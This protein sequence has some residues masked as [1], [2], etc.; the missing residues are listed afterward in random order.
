M[1]ELYAYNKITDAINTSINIYDL[2][3]K[4]YYMLKEQEADII[5]LDLEV[6][7]NRLLSKLNSY[8]E[9]NISTLLERDT[10]K[11]MLSQNNKKSLCS[12]LEYNTI[13]SIAPKM[14]GYLLFIFVLFCKIDD[15]CGEQSFLYSKTT[16]FE[17]SGE[18]VEALEP[19]NTNNTQSK[20]LVYFTEKSIVEKFYAYDPKVYFRKSKEIGSL[21][22]S[23]QTNLFLFQIKESDYITM[24]N[25][26]NYTYTKKIL[27]NSEKVNIALIPFTNNQSYI[28]FI[29]N[30]NSFFVESLEHEK[31]YLAKTIDIL[32][33]LNLKNV[34]I[35]VFPEFVFSSSM[36]QTIRTFLKK[37]KN[38]FALIIFG[39]IWENKTNKCII[40]SGNGKILGEQNKLNRF[41]EDIR[42]HSLG[43]NE[44]IKLDSNNRKINIYDIEGLGRVNTPICIDFVTE[45]Y[46][47]FIE[48]IKV[49]ICFSP[50]YTESL[51]NFNINANRL[52]THNYAS[53]FLCNS[54]IPMNYK[55][56]TSNMVNKKRY[57]LL[58]SYIPLKNK[59]TKYMNYCKCIEPDCGSNLKSICVFW[60][61]F[62]L[63]RCIIKKVSL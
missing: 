13:K 36:L 17:N 40:L 58:F 47:K 52:G 26:I 39:T 2:Y 20:A 12:L 41:H 7:H 46:Y 31:V 23:Y 4:L 27:T 35:V 10:F 18:A 3:L 53:V 19:L 54:C 30:G 57:P 60:I 59:G 34:N 15:I 29:R 9:E 14:E 6:D 28:K 32:N 5:S 50:T 48:D 43:S 37:E 44:G 61:K 1:D 63:N 45:D 42:I 24:I 8:Y 49:N 16:Y 56:I 22:E 25:R 62:S 55:M 11:I 38:N 21:I 33:K 51:K